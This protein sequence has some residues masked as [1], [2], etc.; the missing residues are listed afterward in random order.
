M[1]SVFRG[2]FSNASPRQ[3]ERPQLLHLFAQVLDDQA[4]PLLH[5]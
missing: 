2:C 4:Q 3:P 1:Q 5:D